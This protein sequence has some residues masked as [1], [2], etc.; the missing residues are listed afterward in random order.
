MKNSQRDSTYIYALCSIDAHDF[1]SNYSQQFAMSFDRYKNKLVKQLISPSG[2]PKAYPNFYLLPGI[3]VGVGNTNLTVDAMKDSS[4]TQMK[5]YFDPEYLGVRN[6]EGKPLRLID[7]DSNGALYKLQIINVDRQK[8]PGARYKN[9][10]FTDSLI[11]V[12]LYLNFR[13]SRKWGF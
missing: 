8:K 1:S 7:T 6:S 4:H 9:R 10:G 13:R 2:A 11:A 5:I 3:G 12:Y